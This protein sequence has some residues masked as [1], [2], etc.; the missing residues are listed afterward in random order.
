[1]SGV[2]AQ[3]CQIGVAW[4]SESSVRK[5]AVN[6]RALQVRPMW[7]KGERKVVGG[8]QVKIALVS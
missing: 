4:V 2:T 8:S 3:T 6:A 5:L 7:L 1:M